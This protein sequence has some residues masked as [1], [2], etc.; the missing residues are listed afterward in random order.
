MSALI[1]FYALAPEFLASAAETAPRMTAG[2]WIYMLTAWTLIL[3]LNLYCF[4]RIFR[5]H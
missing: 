3:L 5:K 4:S 1:F 2:S